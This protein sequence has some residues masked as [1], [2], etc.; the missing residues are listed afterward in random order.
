[1]L[2]TVLFHEGQR[3]STFESFNVEKFSTAKM[4]RT[5]AL[6]LRG[7]IGILMLCRQAT[8]TFDPAHRSSHV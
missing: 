1:M 8:V 2:G 5:A 7:R 6:A 3:M 4:R